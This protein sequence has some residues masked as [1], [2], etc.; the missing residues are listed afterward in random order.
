MAKK[1]L[2]FCDFSWGSRPLSAL[3]GSM[4]E[5]SLAGEELGCG[6]D[7]FMRKYMYA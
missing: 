6:S 5:M 2:Y 1:S 4:H 3:S 7:A